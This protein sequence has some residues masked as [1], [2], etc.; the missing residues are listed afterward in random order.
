MSRGARD[1]LRSRF[2]GPVQCPRFTAKGDS[3][4]QR[5]TLRAVSKAFALHPLFEVVGAIAAILT[6]IAWLPQIVKILRER[7]TS[8]ISLGTNAALAT[9]ISLWIVYGFAIGSLPVILS[10]SV[11]LVFILAIVGL[12]LRFG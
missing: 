2:F 4:I 8:D 12:K 10:N 1:V 7:K 5:R 3:G 6:T 11:T 9:G